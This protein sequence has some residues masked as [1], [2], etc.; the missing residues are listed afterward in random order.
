MNPSKHPSSSNKEKKSFVCVAQTSNFG[1]NANG[2]AK[3][4]ARLLNLV[5]VAIGGASPSWGHA[6]NRGSHSPRGAFAE[7][8]AHMQVKGDSALSCRLTRSCVILCNP[9]KPL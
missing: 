6:E 1:E 5:A 4:K 9:R 8:T 3:E 7:R 2:G